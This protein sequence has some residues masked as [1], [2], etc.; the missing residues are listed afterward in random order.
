MG[1][2]RHVIGYHSAQETRVPNAFDDVASTIHQTLADGD[3]AFAR[4]TAAAAAGVGVGAGGASDIVGGD[5]MYRH[6]AGKF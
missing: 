3:A 1:G 6:T 4:A 5:G 2:A